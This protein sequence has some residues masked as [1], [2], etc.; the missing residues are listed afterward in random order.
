MSKI[1]SHCS[2]NLI[3][4]YFILFYSFLSPL[5]FKKYLFSLS[6]LTI[7]FSVASH[8]LFSRSCLPPL[9]FFYFFFFNF[10][11]YG[12]KYLFLFLLFFFFLSIFFLSFVVVMGFMAGCGC[13][14][15]GFCGR[16]WVLL[17]WVSW[18]VVGVVVMV[19]LVWFWLWMWSRT[20]PGIWVSGG[21]S[22]EQNLLV[23]QLFI[24]L[25]KNFWKLRY[26]IFMELKYQQ[27]LKL[28]S[29]FWIIFQ[30]N[31][32]NEIFWYQ[33]VLIHRS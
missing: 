19:L 6:S 33:C 14:T 12:R 13:G 22:I 8:L 24:I 29:R 32:W 7:C 3:I 9:P 17:W 31:Y 11:S 23:N 18:L 27:F 21:W 16:L 2:S 15:N 26:Q 5:L 30:I 25:L 20:E 1:T 4:F 10:L 28:R